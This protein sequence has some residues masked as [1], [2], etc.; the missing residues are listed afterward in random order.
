MKRI[1]N[2]RMYIPVEAFRFWE[3]KDFKELLTEV[4]DKSAFFKINPEEEK[5]QGIAYLF[6]EMFKIRRQINVLN[7]QPEVASKFFNQKWQ[8]PMTGYRIIK[9]LCKLKCNGIKKMFKE[10]PILKCENEVTEATNYLIM[11]LTAF[12]ATAE[13]IFDRLMSHECHN[14]MPDNQTIDYSKSPLESSSNFHIDQKRLQHFP[15]ETIIR[16]L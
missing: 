9:S 1:V 12:K 4:M 13:V 10:M 8:K 11:A 14:C 7:M 2:E 16:I 5:D 3:Q 15:G 6:L